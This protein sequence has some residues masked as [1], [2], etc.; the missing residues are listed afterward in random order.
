MEAQLTPEAFIPLTATSIRKSAA[1]V[2]FSGL[3]PFFVK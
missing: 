2:I 1:L 3:I